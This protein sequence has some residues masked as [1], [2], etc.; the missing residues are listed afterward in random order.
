MGGRDTPGEVCG[1]GTE[2]LTF[3]LSHS[4]GVGG[5]S[6]HG[7]YGMSS[8]YK[9]LAL[10]WMVGATVVLAN[11]TAVRCSETE[12]PDL[13]WAVRGAGS[14]FGVVA[15]FRFKTFAAPEKVTYFVSPVPWRQEKAL[16]AFPAMQEFAR[17]GMP[18][19]L[20][21]RLF[22]TARFVNFEGLYYGDA[23][24][25][26]AA[27]APLQNAT[28]A[29][30]PQTTT[31]GWLDQLSHY[32]G[33]LALNQ[34]YPYVMV[35]HTPLCFKPRQ[36]LVLPASEATPG[37]GWDSAHMNHADRQADMNSRTTERDLPLV[38]SGNERLD[39]DSD[40]GAG[41]LL[42]H[43]GQDDVAGLVPADRLPRG[44][45]VCHLCSELG[46]DLLQPPGQ[47]VPV[48]LLRSGGLGCLPGRRR[49]LHRGMG[50]GHYRLDEARRLGH[51]HQ[52]PG[53]HNGPGHG[54]AP[55]LGDTPP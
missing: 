55:L 48:Q 38:V 12:N 32:G 52:L 26:K 25:L 19:E 50:Q 31:A 39:R 11:G 49:G 13:F 20:T 4:V 30:A 42:V 41:E 43:H 14:A 35:S 1:A 9:G 21:M 27:L 10:D 17:N 51:V 8:H 22:I 15:E 6:L 40:Q 47:A 45:V 46:R 7:G 53:P 29:L 36:P 54:T 24:G 3:F 34:T 44:V 16:T 18:P 23:A 5:H 33:G 37:G 2:K 28:G